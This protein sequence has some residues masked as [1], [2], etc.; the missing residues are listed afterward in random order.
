VAVFVVDIGNTRAHVGLY[1]GGRLHAVR[2]VPHA[3]LGD[4]RWRGEVAYAS[5]NPAAERRFLKAAPHAARL[6][7]DFPPA[8][9]VR[10]RGS[11][12]DRQANAAA[13]WARCRRACAVIDLGTAITVD[14]V[15]SRGEFV[16]GMIAPGLRL[17]ARALHEH[18][19]QLPRVEP[20]VRRTIGR[21][22]RE[23]IEAGLS[24]G[25]EGLIREVRRALRVRTIGT[26]GDARLFGGLLDEVVPGLTLEGIAISYAR[27]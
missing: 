20:R 15:N 19:A 3:R 12:L 7:R 26:G 13:A 1:E 17:Q 5:V 9:T 2:H 11:G 6:G 22:T 8:I 27:R 16:G 14:V 18:T 23:A 4:A 25:V 24:F 21:G 10:C